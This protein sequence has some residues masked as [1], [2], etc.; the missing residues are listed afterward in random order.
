MPAAAEPCVGQELGWTQ[1]AIRA[2]PRGGEGQELRSVPPRA[3]CGGC[4]RGAE[5]PL[6][7]RCPRGKPGSGGGRKTVAP[8]GRKRSHRSPRQPLLR[9][10]LSSCGSSSSRSPSGEGLSETL[11]RGNRG[12]RLVSHGRGSGARKPALLPAAHGSSGAQRELH[13]ELLA[14][15]RFQ[16][17]PKQEFRGSPSASRRP[18]GPFG[19]RGT[20]A[21]L[22][23]RP[24]RGAPAPRP[25]EPVSCGC[26]GRRR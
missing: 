22:S 15:P 4:P 19:R 11:P 17:A 12:Q 26:C 25:G 2:S 10:P 20:P 21:G 7:S 5:I 8:A 13:R 3:P 16:S 14:F 24:P 6:G 1:G 18:L 23:A 9:F